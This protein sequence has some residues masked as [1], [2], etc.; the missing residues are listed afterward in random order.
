M[1]NTGKVCLMLHGC[2]LQE[3][4]HVKV[5]P[6]L[7][8]PDERALF[9]I[10]LKNHHVPNQIIVHPLV[11]ADMKLIIGGPLELLWVLVQDII[12]AVHTV[13]VNDSSFSK[14]KR[15][16]VELRLIRSP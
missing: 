11:I 5:E 8:H 6:L 9:S 1:L 4:Q 15:M 3:I 10:H 2:C 7:G 13:L 12:G 14:R 16:L